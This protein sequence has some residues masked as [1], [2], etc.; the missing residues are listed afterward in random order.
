MSELFRFVFI[1]LHV[2]DSDVKYCQV[3]LFW[4]ASKPI[5]TPSLD[6]QVRHF[7]DIEV[8]ITG[9]LGQVSVKLSQVTKFLPRV[10]A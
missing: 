9:Q 2:A 5:A 10:T 8:R 7:A 6:C 1:S 4:Q 3:G